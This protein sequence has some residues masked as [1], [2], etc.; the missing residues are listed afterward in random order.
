M[1]AEP[2]FEST[3]HLVA[4]LLSETESS[5]RDVL[6]SFMERSERLDEKGNRERPTHQDEIR[7]ILKGLEI[8]ETDAVAEAWLRLPGRSGYGLHAR[9][10]RDGLARPRPVNQDYRQFWDEI[11]SILEVV[12]ERFE[13]RYLESHRTLD[14][15]LA[16]TN[17]TRAHAQRRALPCTLFSG[18]SRA[19]S[20]LFDL[21]KVI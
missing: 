4:H 2:P 5:L 13:S 6:E 7:A 12:L 1:A 19:P 14:T 18:A 20:Q 16:V 11:Q 3:T 21:M 15:L 17:P 9:A 8:P 10:H